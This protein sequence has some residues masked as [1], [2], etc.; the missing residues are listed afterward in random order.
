[1]TAHLDDLSNKIKAKQQ[2][3]QKLK[4]LDDVKLNLQQDALLRDDMFQNFIQ[5][6]IAEKTNKSETWSMDDAYK[7]ADEHSRAQL[8]H[9]GV[10]IPST[11]ASL[12]DLK[13][14]PKIVDQHEEERQGILASIGKK[15]SPETPA[16][17]ARQS[18][19]IAP[20]SGAAAG[21]YDIEKL[22][23]QFSDPA[24][25]QQLSTDPAALQ[26]AQELAGKLKVPALNQAIDQA[27]KAAG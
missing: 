9:H 14:N 6:F 20:S 5:V 3:R 2:A 12:K 13:V 1:M 17:A 8:K 22:T 25:I 23:R 4:D 11:H 21:G 19:G 26:R 27:Q 10:I 15:D 18:Q 16:M 7:Y 24:F